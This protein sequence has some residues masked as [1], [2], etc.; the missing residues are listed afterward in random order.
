MNTMD[1]EFDLNDKEKEILGSKI[2]AIDKDEDF[3][4][5]LEETNILLA[6]KKKNK[7]PFGKKDKD[8]DKDGDDDTTKKGDTDK[9]AAGKDKKES[10]ASKEEDK[11]NV[12]ETVI[13]NG[14][15]K[16]SA[17]ANSTGGSGTSL[18]ERMSNAFGITN[19][20]VENK[21]KNRN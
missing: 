14:E 18:S 2:K 19:W 5:F 21:K 12:V 1:T 4:K 15:K 3:T 8:P 13:Q 6:A 7:M 9:D 10:N 17:I 11:T 20:S 16:E